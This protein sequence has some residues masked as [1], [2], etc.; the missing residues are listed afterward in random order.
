V[1]VPYIV[2]AMN[3][4]D[5][6]DDPELLDL[7]ELEVR[8]LLKTYQFPGDDLPVVRVSALGALNGE[9]PWERSI[10]V[11][12]EAV[13]GTIPVPE[14][15]LHKPFLMT[16]ESIFSTR[17]RGP[18]V[19]GRIERGIVRDGDEIEIVGLRETQKAVVD[20]VE[21]FR[22]P[23]RKGIAGDNVALLL[24]G[25]EEGDVEQG[26]VIAK[27]G[28]I[29]AHVRFTAHVSLL[30]NTERGVDWPLF[31]AAPSRF[32]FRSADVAGVTYLPALFPIITPGGQPTIGV[33]LARPIPLEPGL[34]FAIVN[35]GRTVGTGIVASLG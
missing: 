12:M 15:D 25:V 28:S 10:E 29:R 26:Q 19:S 35:V 1:G 5:M 31:A 11:L 13:D 24:R 14:L 23:L 3:K 9:P 7:V 17:G 34:R 30:P 33:Q 32:V 4:V 27:P 6:V 2:V 16:V 18:I 20:R 8:E 21:M 22:M